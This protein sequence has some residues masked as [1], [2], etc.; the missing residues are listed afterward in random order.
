MPFQVGSDVTSAEAQAIHQHAKMYS[1]VS[2]LVKLDWLRS[3]LRE[4]KLL[5]V[6]SRDKVDPTLLLH[7]MKPKPAPVAKAEIAQAEPSQV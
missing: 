6:G 3:C 2:C 4:R 7:S 5:S 1:H